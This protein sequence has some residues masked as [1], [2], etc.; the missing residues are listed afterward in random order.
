MIRGWQS[1]VLVVLSLVLLVAVVHSQTPSSSWFGG[2]LAAAEALH[3]AWQ[4][5]NANRQCFNFSFRAS[6]ARD[7]FVYPD[8]ATGKRQ[9]ARKG[10]HGKAA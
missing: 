7:N 1:C 6:L 3:K 8:F 10:E 4:G 2:H 9:Q 5:D